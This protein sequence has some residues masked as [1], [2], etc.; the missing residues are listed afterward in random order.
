[1][2]HFRDFIFYIFEIIMKIVRITIKGASGY[3]PS[4][5]GYEDKV[6]LTESSIS[7]EFRQNRIDDTEG[8]TYRKW[9]YKTTSTEF[10]AIFREVA[11]MTPAVM[12][13][14]EELL[15]DDI[16]PTEI[17]VTYDDRHQ[18]RRCFFCP[19]EYFA[20]YFRLIKKLV[21]QREKVPVVL[22]TS[23]DAD[24]F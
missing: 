24:Q 2:P 6:I 13:K 15:A 5:E 7:Y 17:T 14:D 9:S 23:E 18:Q 3:G 1:M 10:K 11:A 21:P 19:G 8:P 22:R 4:D 16:G 12:D 20:E